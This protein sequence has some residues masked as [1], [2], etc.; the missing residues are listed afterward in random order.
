MKR[1]ALMLAGMGLMFAPNAA[2]AKSI[3]FHKPGVDSATAQRNYADCAELA[4]GVRV[5]RQNVYSDNMYAMAATSFFAGFFASR[6]RRSLVDNVMRTCMADKGYVRVEASREL[7]KELD[8]LPEKER[9]ER[10]YVLSGE[11]QPKG[12]VLPR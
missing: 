1:V 11:A 12:K 6:E 4:G 3:Y 7:V 10:L 5:A 9:V 8:R 2:Q